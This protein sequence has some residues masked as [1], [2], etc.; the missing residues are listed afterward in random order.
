MAAGIY[1]FIMLDE[2]MKFR[3][4]IAAVLIVATTATSWLNQA[5]LAGVF[6]QGTGIPIQPRNMLQRPQSQSNQTPALQNILHPVDYPV[7]YLQAVPLRDL[8]IPGLDKNS[9]DILGFNYFVAVDNTPYADMSSLYRSNRLRGKSNFVTVDYI[10]HPYFAFTNRVL[11]DAIEHHIAAELASLLKAMMVTTIAEYDTTQDTGIRLDVE[12]N[13]AYLALGLKLLDSKYAV[14]DK[15]NTQKLVES[16]LKMINEGIVAASDI[17]DYDEDYSNYIPQGWYTTSPALQNFYR[18]RQWVSH[19]GYPLTEI[20]ARK[21][22]SVNNFR[23]SILLYQ[24]LEKATINGTPALITWKKL[25]QAWK[26]LGCFEGYQGNNVLLPDK[27]QAVL[28]ELSPNLKPNLNSLAEPLYRAKLILAMKRQFSAGLNSAS[29]NEIQAPERIRETQAVFALLPPSGD[30]E[31]PWIKAI[32]Y[33]YVDQDQAPEIVP[34]SLP[35]LHA[36]GDGQADNIML[37][38]MSRMHPS[39]VAFIPELERLVRYSDK[40]ARPWGVL[41]GY[42]HF[43]DVGAQGPLRT[44]V[45]MSRRT[46]SAFAAWVDSHIAISPPLP[47]TQTVAG[48]AGSAAATSATQ[49][50]TTAAQSTGAQKE[51]KTT[52]STPDETSQRPSAGNNGRPELFSNYTQEALALTRNN[53]R[54]QAYFHYLEPS[55]QSFQ[56]ICEDAQLLSR[57]LGQLGYLSTTDAQRFLEFI[58]LCRRL[59]QIAIGELKDQVLPVG[60]LKL[61]GNIDKTMGPVDV[62]LEGI[63]YAAGKESANGNVTGVNMALGHPAQLYVILQLGDKVWLAR[64]ALYSYYEIGGGPISPL[65]WQ[66]KQDY[67]LLRVPFWTDKFDVVVN[68]K[69][70]PANEAQ[71]RRPQKPGS[72]PNTPQIPGGLKLMPSINQPQPNN[73]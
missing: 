13:I 47:E 11:A 53:T 68:A 12:H 1:Q 57:Q 73:M 60:D 70:V 19:M 41:D 64:G 22:A 31:W 66:R 56:A 61:L 69:D 48:A 65:H 16:E 14:P 7:K 71:G 38:R 6:D 54:K 20:G 62:P 63:I 55:P 51:S 30:P 46:E 23:R 21:E 18:A 3:A 26:I 72:Q 37:S 52:T 43:P 33:G 15:G 5:S 34:V 25:H 8:P 50:N 32:A 49:A 17:F 67:S 45:W 10:V 9:L 39:L 42:F 2:I 27:Y 59:T 44:D 35:C 29:I 28:R 4:R 36:H 58:R 24:S 40:Q